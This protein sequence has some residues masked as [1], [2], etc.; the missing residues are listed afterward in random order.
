MARQSTKFSDKFLRALKPQGKPYDIREG[1]GFGV[2]VFPSGARSFFYMYHFDG[3][4]R[5][6][7]LGKYPQLSLADARQKHRDA[8]SQHAK[9][10]DPLAATQ[11]QK[12][13]RREAITVADLIDEYIKNWAKVYK[14]ERS[15]TEDERAL[16][17]DVLPYW[18]KRKAKDIKRTDAIALLERIVR[19]GS[20]G[21]ARNIL[22]VGRKMY[23]FAIERKYVEANPFSRIS[24]AVPATMPRTRSRVLTESEIKYIWSAID[25]SAGSDETKRALKLILVTAQRPGEVIGMHRREIDGEWWTI[26]P[27]RIK[28]EKDRTRSNSVG[29]Q[30]HRVYLSP[31]ALELIGDKDGYIFESPRGGAMDSKALSHVV[32]AAPLVPELVRDT[33]GHVFAGPCGP[34][35]AKALMQLLEKEIAYPDKDKYYGLTRWTPHDLRRTARTQM[36][37]INIPTRHAERVLNH[38][39][40]GI[41]KT[42]DLYRYDPQ[43]KA[44]LTKWAAY[45]EELLRQQV[46]I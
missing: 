37:A 35:D 3:K 14:V 26:P 38:S 43:K 8:V 28:T 21:Q 15:A 7:N 20:P 13:E 33:E 17:K 6:L 12:R 23:E 40:P 39:L 16:S 36:S 31:L 46:T 5:F 4:R 29:P 27:E 1:D 10:I 41:Q 18:G 30:P 44:A 9:G 11:E 25:K 32:H 42:Y 34:V 2:R 24:K 45:L 22:K 19:R